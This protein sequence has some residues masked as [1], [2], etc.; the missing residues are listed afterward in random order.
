V[1]N[2][3]ASEKFLCHL[4]AVRIMSIVVLLKREVFSRFDRNRPLQFCVNPI[5]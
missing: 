3:G 4:A 2:I 5:F 1:G